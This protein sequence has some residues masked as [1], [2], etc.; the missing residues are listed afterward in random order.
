MRYPL[1]NVSAPPTISELCTLLVFLL[2][3]IPLVRLALA[4]RDAKMGSN[5]KQLNTRWN[6]KI[7]PF[8]QE[9]YSEVQTQYL[10]QML[11]YMVQSLLENMELL[12]L[13]ELTHALKTCFKVLSKVQMPPSYLDIETGSGSGV[14]DSQPPQGWVKPFGK[15]FWDRISNADSPSA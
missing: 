6:F 12:G 1:E 14:G 7:S 11:S 4:I 3:V 5:I 8:L 10:P 9:L 2:D 13:P 15:L